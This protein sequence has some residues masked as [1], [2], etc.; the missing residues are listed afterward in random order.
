MTEAQREIQRQK[1]WQARYDTRAREECRQTSDIDER[2]ACID[3]VK[4]NSVMR[5]ALPLRS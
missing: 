4:Y 3:K 1:D 2:R 5:G